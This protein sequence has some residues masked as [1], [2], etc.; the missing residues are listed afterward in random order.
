MCPY[1][2]N[3]ECRF[4]VRPFQLFLPLPPP[5]YSPSSLPIRLY[6][7]LQKSEYRIGRGREGEG[8]EAR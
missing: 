7:V 1:M 3:E 8:R 5:F 2:I 6:V 4:P